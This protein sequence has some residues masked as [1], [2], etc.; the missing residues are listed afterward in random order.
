VRNEDT[1]VDDL[2]PFDSSTCI[3]A[4]CAR[5]VPIL[6]QVVLYFDLS[7]SS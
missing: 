7:A 6:V 3:F 1:L 2:L 4:L 5:D